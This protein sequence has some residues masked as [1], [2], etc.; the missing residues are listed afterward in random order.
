MATGW[1]SSNLDIYQVNCTYYDAL[2]RDDAAYLLARAVQFF[3]PGIP[4]VY[5]V[6][7]LAGLNDM[8]LLAATGVGRDI[9][10][11]QYTLDEI[12]RD[13][14]RPVVAAL[15]ELIRFRN[16][17]PAFAGVCEVGGDGSRVTLTWTAG[18]QAAALEADFT[19]AR[20]TL[21]W[22]GPDGQP[23]TC[24]SLLALGLNPGTI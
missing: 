11:H 16:T 15:V 4:Q 21:T 23:N 5:Y 18:E 13:L 14:T 1:A 2:G 22:T 20:A 6:G 19:G 12:T 17:H 7:L 10:R 24:E 3:I 9:N 8:D